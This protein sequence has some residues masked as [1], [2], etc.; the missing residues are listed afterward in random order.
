MPDMAA[1]DWKCKTCGEAYALSPDLMKRE[2]SHHG[3]EGC[4]KTLTTQNVSLW[5]VYRVNREKARG[6]TFDM[7]L[8][9]I[10]TDWEAW[11][12]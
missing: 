4:G 8:S 2:Q 6:E 7:T 1:M 5:T 3:E 9:R 10:I 11:K 12:E